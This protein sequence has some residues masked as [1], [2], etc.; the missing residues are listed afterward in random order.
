MMNRHEINLTQK[1]K[2]VFQAHFTLQKINRRFEKASFEL[3]RTRGKQASKFAMLGARHAQ[4]ARL[5][6]KAERRLKRREK[7]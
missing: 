1:D 3:S 2:L 5:L 7:L 4:L 6:K